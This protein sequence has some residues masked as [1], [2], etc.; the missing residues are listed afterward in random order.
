MAASASTERHPSST[1]G[2]RPALGLRCARHHV[3]PAA[4]PSGAHAD[5]RT[6][7]WEPRPSRN[8]LLFPAPR[9]DSPRPITCRPAQRRVA[10]GEGPALRMRCATIRGI[11]GS[12]PP[13]TK[14]PR[15]K[16]RRGAG[17][18]RAARQRQRRRRRRP[19]DGDGRLP[20]DRIN[21]ASKSCALV[22][23]CSPCSCCWFYHHVSVMSVLSAWFF[24]LLQPSVLFI[25]Y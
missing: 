17:R 8:R 16:A 18:A 19:G 4:S 10:L 22:S 20:G 15:K 6:S 2:R 21:Q 5:G 3:A 13:R 11:R 9:R 23:A 14:L 1:A 7:L 25:V 12:H 24:L